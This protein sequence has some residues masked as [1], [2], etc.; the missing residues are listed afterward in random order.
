MTLEF[1]ISPNSLS[2]PA[3]GAPLWNNLHD[4]VAHLN[5]DWA[6]N[7]W[8]SVEERGG[9][10]FTARHGRVVQWGLPLKARRDALE[11][12]L[13]DETTKALLERVHTGH[14][15]EWDNEQ[16]DRVGRLSEDAQAAAE[17]LQDH[18]DDWLEDEVADIWDARSW[19]TADGTNSLSD[20]LLW[21][22]MDPEDHSDEALNE[23]AE[24]LEEFADHEEVVLDGDVLQVLEEL[25]GN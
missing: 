18:L 13:Q 21:E 22:E 4:G 7:V 10:T 6:G 2:G 15:V 11:A 14:E 8:L 19:I 3:H 9:E 25:R 12:V 24:K 20:L 5:L 16:G 1:N 17:E 23:L